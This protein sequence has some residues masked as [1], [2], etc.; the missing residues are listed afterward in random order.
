LP[1]SVMTAAAIVF[2]L[3]TA[4]VIAFQIGLALGAP[5]G[6]YAMGGA[7]PGRFPARLRIGALIQ[8]ILLAALAVVVLADAGLLMPDLSADYP[9]LIWLAVAFSALSVV[10]NAITRSAVERRIWLP[11]A[12]VMLVS[13]LVVALAGP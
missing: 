3:A 8:A 4:V 10:L 11:V 2:A 9:W 13:S 1:Q 7:Y 12:V 6:R 5:W